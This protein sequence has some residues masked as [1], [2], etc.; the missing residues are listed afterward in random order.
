MKVII[1]V[2]ILYSSWYEV[3]VCSDLGGKLLFIIDGVILYS[4]WYEVNVCPALEGKLLLMVLYYT[5]VDMKLMFVQ[6]LKGS[7]Y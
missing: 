6:L 1:N 4:C 3:N 5:V 2:V 7:Y